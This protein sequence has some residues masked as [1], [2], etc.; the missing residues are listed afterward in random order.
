[1]CEFES[2]VRR[3][4]KRWVEKGLHPMKK[5]IGKTLCIAAALLLV[6]AIVI[7]LSPM[8]R[9][10][11]RSCAEVCVS[12]EESGYY[13]LFVEKDYLQYHCY[14]TLKNLAEDEK[15]VYIRSIQPIEFLFGAMK[16]PVMKVLS[17][18]GKEK[19]FVVPAHGTVTYDINFC[20]KTGWNIHKLNRNL[21]T[22]LVVEDHDT[23]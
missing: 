16:T 8:V 17:E 19:S 11:N 23:A 6:P 20:A 15:T 2:Q 22:I 13:D 9:L 5:K 12:E 10:L 18:N 21:P 1:M 14:V 3:S 7:Q 4:D